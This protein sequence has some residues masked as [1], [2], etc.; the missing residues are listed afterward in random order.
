MCPWCPELKPIQK[1]LHLRYKWADGDTR[2]ACYLS[3]DWICFLRAASSAKL[4][5]HSLYSP[6]PSLLLFPWLDWWFDNS[7]RSLCAEHLSIFSVFFHPVE[8]FK[9]FCPIVREPAVPSLL[10]TRWYWPKWLSKVDVG[11]YLRCYPQSN[12]M[13]FWD[14]N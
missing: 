14:S 7:I 13:C 11:G 9:S 12:M 5:P 3:L 4:V 10:W 8:G 1:Y 6:D 2:G